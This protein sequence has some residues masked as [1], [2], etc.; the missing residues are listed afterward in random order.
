[1]ST[2]Y[3]STRS[4]HELLT[5]KQAI[6]Q[7]IAADG[8]LFICDNL[9]EKRIDLQTVCNNSFM[10]NA[11]LILSTLL[12][13]FSAAEITNCVN[14]AYGSGFDSFAITPI[15]ALGSSWLLE[16]WHGPTSAFKDIALQMLPQLM[17]VSR[18][19]DDRN[20]MIVTATSGD[21]GKAALAGFANVAGCGITVF[22]PEGK[23]SDMQRLQMVTQAGTNVA[24]SA[25]E[26]N[27]D[28]IQT[29]VKHIFANPD[30]AEQL[31]AQNIV[32]S[33]A[34]SINIGRLI[35][36][37]VY[38]FDAYAQLVRAGNITLGDPL[39]F[40]V[41]TGN[42]G[43]VLAG[44]FAKLMGLPVAK[45][46]VAS[47]ANDVLFD[48]IRT[49]RYD[50]R[51][52]FNKTISPS[53]DILVSS[54]L[55][56]LLYLLSEGDCELIRSYMTQL[57]EQGFYQIS[58]ELLSKLQENFAGGRADDNQTRAAIHKAWTDEKVLLD[59]HTAVAVSVMDAAKPSAA[60]R[61]VLST[62]NAYKFSADVLEALTGTPCT[63]SGFEA[64]DELQRLT[65]IPAPTQLSKLRE[66][67][68]LH[69]QVCSLDA[70]TAVVSTAC[71]KSF[72]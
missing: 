51:R 2:F 67:A 21:T 5:S 24:V 25:V 20:V 19:D 4:T 57:S 11:V 33:S 49:G 27:F 36:Q 63:L 43:N 12:D 38:Y 1:M 53:M 42:F 39:E 22:Y 44:Y 50:R 30:L 41:P 23:V 26:G 14:A 48:F 59:T 35:P 32:L 47:N 45:L 7:G 3:H 54:N 72:A 6:L 64:M 60:C 34:N 16:L 37:V 55:E 40:Y 10:Q 17:S 58:D 46:T 69:P 62:A 15:S 66:A 68:V 31:A 8:G 65:G 9:A 13:D 71:E 70:M 18:H 28:D 52:S 29:Q 61:V 56:R